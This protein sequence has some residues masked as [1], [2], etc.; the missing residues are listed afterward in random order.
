M[1]KNNLKLKIAPLFLY[2]SILFVYL[3][4]SIKLIFGVGAILDKLYNIND[5]DHCRGPEMG[6]Q[7]L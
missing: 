1:T 3:S 6:P 2:N 5:S 4:I 7:R